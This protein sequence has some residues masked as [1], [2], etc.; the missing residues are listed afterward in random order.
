MG[1]FRLALTALVACL[2]IFGTGNVS[3]DDQPIFSQGKARIL[4]TGLVECGGWRSRPSAVGEVTASNGSTWTV[5]APVHYDKSLF[6]D[7]LFNGCGGKE[8]SGPGEI[9]LNTI[10]V[11]TQAGG[12]EVFTAYLFADNY[13]E[14]FVNG[15]LLGVDPVPFTPFNSNIIRFTAQRPFTIAAMLVDW[16]ESL[17]I[18]TESG[19]GS[20]HHPGDGGFV[21]V[22]KDA[23]G[24]TLAV[25]DKTWRA[26]TYYIAPLDNK[27][28]LKI[29]GGLRD[30][31]ACSSADRRNGNGLFA[32]H[33][34][35]SAKWATV[36]FDDSSWPPATT[37]S[38][39]TVGVDNKRSYTNFAEIFDN[40]RA[41]AQ[42]IWSP[43]LGLDNLVLVRKVVR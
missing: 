41:T 37:F 7:D 29:T 30:S 5:P 26:Q 40:P 28:C 1:G 39:D 24:K 31:R 43:N 2:T 13:F 10:P 20:S 32:A 15:K 19:R 36:E 21:A 34:L 27:G 23:G 6:A 22:I 16:E 35:I 12:T 33:W 38:N 9:D 3:A 8:Y 42:F 25:T 18:G 4:K 14:F 17:G 11:R